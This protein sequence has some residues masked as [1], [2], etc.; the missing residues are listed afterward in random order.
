MQVTGFQPSEQEFRRFV[1]S[2]FQSKREGLDGLIHACVGLAGESGECLDLAK[3]SWVYDKPLD[4]PKLLEEMGD[5]LH[6]FFMTLIKLEELTGVHFTLGAVMQNNVDKLNKR[7]P[8]GFTKADAI[9][10]A[11]VGPAGP[12]VTLGGDDHYNHDHTGS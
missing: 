11:D 5:T 3:K 7:Y 1:D 10:R 8:N 12:T 2:L 4:V 9:A 6:Y